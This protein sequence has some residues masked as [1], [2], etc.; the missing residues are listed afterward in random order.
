[1]FI[2]IISNTV[3]FIAV[4][5][6]SSSVSEIFCNFLTVATFSWVAEENGLLLTNTLQFKLNHGVQIRQK[7]STVSFKNYF[8][9]II[10]LVRSITLLKYPLSSTL[11]RLILN[12]MIINH[13]KILSKVYA[14]Q[15]KCKSHNTSWGGFHGGFHGAISDHLGY[16]GLLPWSIFCP[17]V[18]CPFSLPIAIPFS[19]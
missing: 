10:N 12:D 16:F 6:F 5:R 7:T 9:W 4:T 19:A 18:S 1:M 13:S 11:Q 2:L 3:S 8:S 17:L 15:I 14:S